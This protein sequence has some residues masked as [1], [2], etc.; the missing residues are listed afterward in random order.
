MPT[1]KL[2]GTE[3]AYD[4]SGSGPAMVLVHGLALDRRMW[5]DQVEALSDVATVIR[6]DVRGYGR[7]RRA[8]GVR[9]T[10]AGDLVALLDHLGIDAAILVGLS[11]GG[12]IVTEATLIAPERVRALVLLDSVLD[13]VRWDDAAANGMRACSDAFASGGLDAAKA[14]WLRHPFFAPA[15]RNPEV[16]ARLA[17]MT[18]DYGGSH[19]D[20]PDSH[21]AHPDT[22]A[23]LHTIAV[24]T[25]V[26]VG[27]LD[28]PGFRAMADEFTARIPDAR[29][30]IVPDAGHMSNMEAPAAVNRILRE[31][32]LGGRG[33][34]AGMTEPFEDD[35]SQDPAQP[36]VGP[37]IQF[38]QMIVPD[39]EQV[40]VDNDY[41]EVL[42]TDS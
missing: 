35:S 24:P 6:Y 26:V 27:A 17:A 5:D 42:D 14:A 12:Q 34:L 3:L 29:Q 4:V 31:F 18:G 33:Y 28:V 40:E 10:H 36:A 23:L 25:L 22:L 37:A 39:D 30:V 16:A 20:E 8:P 1:L 9:Y 15:L 41:G 21:G 2:P 7:S 11:M 13:G 32:A 38:Q 19:W